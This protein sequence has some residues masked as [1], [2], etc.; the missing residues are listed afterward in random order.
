MTVNSAIALGSNLGDSLAILQGAIAALDRHPNVSVTRCSS[1]YQ[2][3]PVGPPQPDYFNA[4]AL[5]ATTLPPEALLQLLLAIEA[6]F[7]RVRRER[8]G[9]RLLDLDLLLVESQQCQTSRLEL[10]HPRMWERAFVMVP[11]AE[12]APDWPHPATGQTVAEICATL[13]TDDIHRLPD[14]C[15][16]VPPSS[17]GL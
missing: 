11:L 3:A 4:C 6:Q 13:S 14:V 12:I 7:G 10:P 9:A 2:T 8:W 16:C 1:I 17:R 15:V 5:L